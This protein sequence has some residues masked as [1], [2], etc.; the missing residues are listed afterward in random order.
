MGCGE[1]SEHRWIVD[2]KV[3]ILVPVYNR[4]NLIGPCIES[5]LTQTVEDIEVVACDNCS[6][7]GTWDILQ[8]YA[9]RDPR[10]RIFRNAQNL[11]PVR[12]WAR[13]IE[14]AR[15]P[16][17]KLL[18]SDD[19]I[20]PTYLE[21]TLPF[22]GMPGVGLVFTACEIGEEPGNSPVHYSFAATPGVWNPGRFLLGIVFAYDVPPSPCAAL[23]HTGDLR[24]HLVT[25]G[26]AG[27][28]REFLRTGAGPDLLLLLD[29][30][31]QHGRVAHIPERLVFFRAHPGSISIEES[32]GVSSLRRRA[33][34]WFLARNHPTLLRCYLSGI[35]WRKGMAEVLKMIDD[36][37]L[38]SAPVPHGMG[39]MM[40]MMSR[41]RRSF[42][43]RSSV[44]PYA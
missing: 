12:N 37:E 32:D 9:T 19:L 3:S 33:I 40:D 34:A 17:A 14:E 6:T 36:L 24:D 26:P 41:L 38:S 7:D 21:R 28:A 5:A 20:A 23:S 2:P 35:R 18:F 16:Y 22:I 15:A 4:K 25:S 44:Q 31:H 39:Y 10:L 27:V 30:E 11:G 29:A 8:D 1:I 42:H 43:R 13:C